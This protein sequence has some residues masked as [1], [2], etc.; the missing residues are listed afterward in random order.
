M[1]RVW[2]LDTET[3]GTGAEMV[4]LDKVRKQ[5]APRGEPFWVPPERRPREPKPA[6]PRV[7]RKF[8]VV[9]VLSRELLADDTGARE[10]LGVLSGVRSMVDVQVYVWQAEKWRLL[11]LDEL[12]TLWER[13]PDAA[14]S[15]SRGT[16]TLAPSF[17][18]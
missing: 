1:G 3:K 8:R 17:D 12:R 6:E 10:A 9:D 18:A 11:T 15:S 2:V 13:R 16:R 4:P 14:A 5:P 7:P